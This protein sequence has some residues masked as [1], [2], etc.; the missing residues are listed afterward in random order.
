MAVKDPTVSLP[1]LQEE[2]VGFRFS[3]SQF[4]LD[5]RRRLCHRHYLV[6]SKRGKSLKS[7]QAW[8][9]L[10]N[11]DQLG[12]YCQQIQDSWSSFLASTAL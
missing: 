5:Y 3:S 4:L 2:S 7:G 6:G 11:V 9:C 1:F 10:E 12:A 8:T